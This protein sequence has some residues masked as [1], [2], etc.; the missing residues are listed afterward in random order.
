M[1][2]PVAI[3]TG[4][5]S[6]IGAAIAARLAGRYDLILSHLDDD[7]DLRL[8]RAAAEERGATTTAVTGDLTNPATIEL[9]S[10]EVDRAADRLEVLVSNAGAYPRIPWGALS[11]TRSD[12]RSRST[13]S[14][15]RPA[16]RS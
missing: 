10:H 8:V 7:P 3:V 13:S 16:P 5:G 14:R 15:T 11:L 4:A 9:L 6:G 2:R 12:G 1:S